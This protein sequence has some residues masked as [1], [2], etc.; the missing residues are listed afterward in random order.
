[1]LPASNIKSSLGP[2]ET[3]IVLVVAALDD[4]VRFMLPTI[5]ICPI[6]KFVLS[7]EMDNAPPEAVPSPSIICTS[8]VAQAVGAVP[9]PSAEVFQLLN[10]LQAPPVAPVQ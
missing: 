8:E 7:T 4:K 1:M 10:V 2:P 5:F 6:V 3:V 9:D